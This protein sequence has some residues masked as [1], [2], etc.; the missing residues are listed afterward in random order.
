LVARLGELAKQL[1]GRLLSALELLGELLRLAFLAAAVL[2]L[3]L[4]VLG[5]LELEQLLKAFEARLA[6]F[7]QIRAQ[8]E[9]LGAR[10]SVCTRACVRESEREKRGAGGS[11]ERTLLVKRA[12]SATIFFDCSSFLRQKSSS[13]LTTWFWM[14][15]ANAFWRSPNLATRPCTCTDTAAW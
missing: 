13:G 9:E 4:L 2:L 6:V 7:E 12:S 5:L 14:A 15:S 3:L 8:G 1:L 11:G 10:V